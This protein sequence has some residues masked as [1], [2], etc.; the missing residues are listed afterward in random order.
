MSGGAVAILPATG[1]PRRTDALCGGP[2]TERGRAGMTDTAPQH[3]D[4]RSPTAQTS[5]VRVGSHRL[6][7]TAPT[8][9]PATGTGH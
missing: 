7:S 2:R 8:D 5:P 6:R 3:A 1:G 9:T 4:G